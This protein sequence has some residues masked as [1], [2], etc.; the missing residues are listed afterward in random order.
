MSVYKRLIEAVEKA[1]LTVPFV[2]RDSLYTTVEVI[3]GDILI[4]EIRKLEE[5]DEEANKK[6]LGWIRI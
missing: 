2:N 1:K 5:E 4:A 6:A 3:D